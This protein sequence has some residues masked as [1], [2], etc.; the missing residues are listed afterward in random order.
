LWTEG[1]GAMA[2]VVSLLGHPYG[3]FA[4]R[5]GGHY[6]PEGDEVGPLA[7]ESDRPGRAIVELQAEDRFR[8]DGKSLTRDELTAALKPKASADPP[9]WVLLRVP[10]SLPFSAVER[11]IEAIHSAGIATIRLASASAS[12]RPL[13]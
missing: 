9:G 6:A 2:G 12:P 7:A 5:E 8:L 1:K 11:A 10:P 13:R 3:F 4:I